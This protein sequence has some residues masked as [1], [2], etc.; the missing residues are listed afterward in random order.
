MNNSKKQFSLP[1]LLTVIFSFLIIFSFPSHASACGVGTYNVGSGQT[2]T[3]INA[4]ISAVASDCG[5]TAWN[6]SNTIHVFSGTYSEQI[7]PG[8]LN[9][10]SLNRLILQFDSGAIINGGSTRAFGIISDQSHLSI[11][12][13]LKIQNT[14]VIAVYGSGGSDWIIAG[15]GNP[16]AGSGA[17]GGIEIGPNTGSGIGV[18]F[19]IGASITNVYAHNNSGIGV[20]YDIQGGSCAIQFVKAISNSTD[21]VNVGTNCIIHDIDTENN[22]TRGGVSFVGATVT[23]GTAYNIFSK[24]NRYGLQANTGA[25]GVT[26]YNSIDIGSYA[27]GNSDNSAVTHYYNDTFVN[28][29]TWGIFYGSNTLAGNIVKNCLFYVGVSGQHGLYGGTGSYPD[30]DY[31]N[32]YVVPA[33][34]GILGQWSS[35]DYSSLSAWKIALP[36]DSHSISVDPLLSNISGTTAVDFQWPTNSPSKDAGTTI[37]SVLTDYFGTTRPQGSA[38]DIGFYE[39]PVATT[40]TLTGPSSGNAGS[41][42]TNFTVTPNGLYTGTIT[43]TP[44]GSGSTGLSATVL[45]FSSSLVAQT[46]TIT[47]TVAGSI[48]LTSTNNGSVINP[49]NLTYTVNAIIPGVP[50]IGT[51]TASNG[52]ATVTFTAPASNGG[53]TITSYTATSN[54]GNITGTLTQAGSGTIVVSSL[55]NGTPYTFTVTATNVVGTSSASAASNSVTPIAPSAPILIISSGGGYRIPQAISTPSV[56][57]TPAPSTTPP[58]PTTTT[59]TPPLFPTPITPTSTHT[60][61]TTLQSFLNTTVPNTHLPLNGKFGPQTKAALKKF[62]RLHHLTPDGVMGKK[63]REVMEGILK[64]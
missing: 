9:T 36:I 25:T 60:S 32:I 49:G 20:T 44:T 12:G 11:L 14:T 18:N 38:Y 64:L 42:S 7:G 6:Q 26:F 57:V 19:T 47:P 22:S 46:F 16:L 43:L 58:P 53:A 52:S 15:T 27:G 8:G 41:A 28:E 50:T 45:T 48:T 17:N 59:T 30:S 1:L 29:T 3:T 34:G 4:A 61:I 55:T 5:S 39:F 23:S 33:S 13:S 31:N 62:Q 2:Y 37:G 56:V 10:T 63:T 51:A 40:F 21:G 24:N 54:P 35:I